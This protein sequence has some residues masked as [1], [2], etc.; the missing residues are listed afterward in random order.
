MTD[1]FGVVLAG[2]R[3][4]RMGVDKSLLSFHEIPQ[5]EY[6]FSLLSSFCVDVYTS[7]RTGQHVPAHLNPVIDHLAMDSPLNGLLSVFDSMSERAWL[8]VPVDMPFIGNEAVEFLLT[9]RDPSKLATCFLDSDGE[10]PEPLFTVWERE[11]ISDLREFCKAGGVSPREFLLSSSVNLLTVPDAHWLLNVNT[12]TDWE[13]WK[14]IV[15]S[16]S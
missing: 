15:N 16:R 8:S 1:L 13:K 4:S 2:G 5:R 12:M 9:H 7:C 11:A 14:A 3:S 10:K 6:L